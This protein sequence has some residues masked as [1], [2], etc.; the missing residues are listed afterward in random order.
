MKRLLYEGETISKW[1][2]DSSQRFRMNRKWTTI[3]KLFPGSL[4]HCSHLFTD[5]V[6]LPVLIYFID[7]F[8]PPSLLPDMC[9]SSRYHPHVTFLKVYLSLSKLSQPL[10]LHLSFMREVDLT[11]K[12]IRDQSF[13]LDSPEQ[14]DWWRHLLL[15]ISSYFVHSED[16]PCWGLTTARH[17]QWIWAEGWLM[18]RF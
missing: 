4:F 8:P 17:A 10:H 18:F 3:I 1:V 12:S 14:A 16:S 2:T 13:H 7:V 15:L 9:E 11:G 5:F 6:I